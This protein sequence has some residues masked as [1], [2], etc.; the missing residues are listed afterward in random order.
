MRG[1]IV[2]AQETEFLENDIAGTLLP[3]VS[4]E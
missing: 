2:D 4:K 1:E 3:K